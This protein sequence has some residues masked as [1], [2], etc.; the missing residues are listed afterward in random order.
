MHRFARGENSPTRTKSET[1]LPGHDVMSWPIY[2]V[3]CGTCGTCG[4]WVIVF[5]FPNKKPYYSF[6][7]CSV[8]LELRRVLGGGSKRR[9]R[10]KAGFKSRGRN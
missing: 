10:R 1:P 2:S 6:R 3:F 4:V 9:S 7:V 8:R 5:P